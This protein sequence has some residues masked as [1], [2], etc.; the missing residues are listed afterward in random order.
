MD[1]HYD[2]FFENAQKATDTGKF[3]K[4]PRFQE[5]LKYNLDGLYSHSTK[6]AHLGLP[7]RTLVKLGRWCPT[8][9]TH[10]NY[11][12]RFLEDHDGFQELMSN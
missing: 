1:Q 7:T 11:T 4:L 8:S 9:T 3:M 12:R 6:I 5:N 2:D 10:Y